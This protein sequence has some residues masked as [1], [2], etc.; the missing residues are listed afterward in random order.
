MFT[1]YE[2]QTQIKNVK[3]WYKK[4]H[5]LKSWHY[6]SKC[7]YCHDAVEVAKAEASALGKYCIIII[8]KKNKEE[9]RKNATYNIIHILNCIHKIKK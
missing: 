6:N 1:K 7:K 9:A 5:K 2:K 4:V 3:K 8:A